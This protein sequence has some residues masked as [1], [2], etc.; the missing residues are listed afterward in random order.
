MGVSRNPQ[1]Y[2]FHGECV[3]KCK[4]YACVKE[5]PDSKLFLSVDLNTL[6]VINFFVRN[7]ALEVKWVAAES[8]WQCRLCGWELVFSP[9]VPWAAIPHGSDCLLR[10]CRQDWSQLGAVL[11]MPTEWGLHFCFLLKSKPTLLAFPYRRAR[12]QIPLAWPSVVFALLHTSSWHRSFLLWSL[13]SFTVN[14]NLFRTFLLLFLFYRGFKSSRAFPVC[15][16]NLQCW[17]L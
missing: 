14:N 11:C 7:V 10:P 8:Q 3:E 13:R 17:K 15:R 9:S 5:R 6:R 2:F 16:T 4:C 12:T 1:W